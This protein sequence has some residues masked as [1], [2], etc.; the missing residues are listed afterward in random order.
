MAENVFLDNMRNAFNS[1]PVAD[2]PELKKVHGNKTNAYLTLASIDIETNSLS[3]DGEILTFG[4]N[5]AKFFVTQEKEFPEAVAVG[6][7]YFITGWQPVVTDTLYFYHD[8]L[9][10]CGRTDIHGITLDMLVPHKDEYKTNILKMSAITTA[11]T[12]IVKNGWKF[13]LPYIITYMLKRGVTL[14]TDNINVIEEQDII[15]PRWKQCNG[16]TGDRKLGTLS[17]YIEWLNK[18]CSDNEKFV[19]KAHDALEDSLATSWAFYRYM[20]GCHE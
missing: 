12:I 19:F 7:N 1:T 16:H 13:D 11:Y 2:N 4:Y 3:K 14:N 17:D 18:S 20:R 5:V 8:G 9:V 6:D 15:S 10:D